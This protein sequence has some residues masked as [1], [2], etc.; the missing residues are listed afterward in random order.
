[1]SE[2]LNKVFSKH[3]SFLVESRD[4]IISCYIIV[5]LEYFPYAHVLTCFIFKTPYEVSVL[6]TDGE[7]EA[8]RV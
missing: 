1:M 2:V 8:W 7:T 3:F 4:G 6:I 5:T